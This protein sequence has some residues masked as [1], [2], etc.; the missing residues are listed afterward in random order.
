MI[1]FALCVLL[2]VGCHAAGP[3]AKARD[4]YQ[5][6]GMIGKFFDCD[7]D[8][9]YSQ[10]QCFGSV[11]HCSDAV[12]NQLG[13]DDDSFSIGESANNQDKCKSF[14]EERNCYKDRA[15]YQK[16][17]II[18]LQF[19]CDE[20][21]FYKLI[22]CRGSGCYCVNQEGKVLKGG[23]FSISE[24]GKPGLLAQRQQKCDSL[25]KDDFWNSN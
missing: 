8:G 5:K 6:T 20:D 13:S 17:G 3:C 7:A 4:D 18:G 12:G 2:A 21:G 11:C 19:R 15:D 23:E 14:A 1:A 16:K 25:E 22:Q 9:F 10:I 24:M